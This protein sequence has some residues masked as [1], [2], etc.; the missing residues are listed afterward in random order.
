[1]LDE[2]QPRAGARLSM[3][4]V[5]LAY[6]R[7]IEVGKEFTV[8]DVMEACKDVSHGSV[9]GFM[10]KLVGLG[11]IERLG[12]KR[13]KLGPGQKQIVYTMLNPEMP[14]TAGMWASH[15]GTKDRTDNGRRRWDGPTIGELQA[16]PLTPKALMEKLLALAGEVEAMQPDLSHVTVDQLLAELRSRTHKPE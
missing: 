9:S 7:T 15:G 8:R 1:M 3:T 16:G 4:P 11:M 13:N 6:V 12:Y 10:Y 5:I 14:V 2:I